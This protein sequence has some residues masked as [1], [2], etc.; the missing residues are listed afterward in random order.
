VKLCRLSKVKNHVFQEIKKKG[1]HCYRRE[2]GMTPFYAT[3]LWAIA[4]NYDLY[5]IILHSY[6]LTKGQIIHFIYTDSVNLT[7]KKF[8]A[9]L[10][11][12]VC[13][14]LTVYNKVDEVLIQ[15]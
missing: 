2:N 7:L 8:S 15:K 13:V 10:F 11:S 14:M 3:G 1:K 6:V 5:N 12:S 4:P 9:V